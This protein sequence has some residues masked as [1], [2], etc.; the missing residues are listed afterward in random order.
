MGWSSGSE[1]MKEVLDA[2]DEHVHDVTTRY[3]I[4]KKLIPVWRMQD[5]DTLDELVGDDPAFDRALKE[6][7]S[8]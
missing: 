4:F 6:Y 3:Q 8:R 1:L 2:L 7:E 5:C